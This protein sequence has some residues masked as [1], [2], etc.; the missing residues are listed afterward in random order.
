[1]LEAFNSKERELSDWESL[2]SKATTF[3]GSESTDGKLTLKSITKPFGSVMSL[4]EVVWQSDQ[5]SGLTLS[6]HANGVNGHE[7]GVKGSGVKGNGINGE[8]AV[9]GFH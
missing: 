6:G 7:N 1:M 2:L 9:H 5:T 3:A 4:L 8:F